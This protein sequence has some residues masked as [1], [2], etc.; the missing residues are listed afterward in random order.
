TVLHP[1]RILP[2]IVELPDDRGGAWRKLGAKGIGVALV[3]LVV[4]LFGDEVVLVERSGADTRD[5]TLPDARGVLPRRERIAAAA[6]AVEIADHGQGFGVGCPHGEARARGRIRSGRGHGMRAK[7]LVSAEV[8]SLAE[9]IDVLSCQ[10]H[11][12]KCSGVSA[13]FRACSRE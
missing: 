8:R 9:V 13:K 1:L 6:P 11:T 4:S 12:G 3:D 7:R 5:D 2:A 10:Q